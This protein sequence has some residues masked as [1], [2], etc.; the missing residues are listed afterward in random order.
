MPRTVDY[1]FTLVSPWAFLGH[2]AF[3]DL[4]QAHGAAVRFKPVELSEV[5][6]HTGGLPL[7]KR[8]PA[9]QRY[10]LIELQRWREKRGLS[11][12]LHPRHWPFDGKLADGIV[13][14]AVLDGLNPEPFMRL[15]YKSVWE[16]ERNLADPAIL[17]ELAD[18]AGLPGKALLARAA[19][20]EVADA[21]EQNRQDAIE[22][23]VFGSPGFVLNGE[24]FW[25]QDR[26][27][28]L[29]DA[30]R[31]KRAPYRSDV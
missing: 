16:D 2:Q 29:A 24:P 31:T 25:G 14:A 5:F 19:T 11:F 1:W 8:H 12:K 21:Y 20:A 30:L 17:I 3:L 23:G 27:D 13:V 15:G 9:R 18:A 4:A 22:S 26:I 6:P 28:M 7:P 10:R